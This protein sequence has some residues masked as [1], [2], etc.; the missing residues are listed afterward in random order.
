MIKFENLFKAKIDYMI[1]NI[2]IVLVNTSHPGNIGATARAM[3]CMGFKEL[4]LVAPKY[5]PSVDATARAAGADDILAHAKVCD[6][7]HEAV[8]DCH[9][10][11][12]TSARVRSLSLPLL[13]PKELV[14]EI[15]NAQNNSKIAIVFGRENNGLTNEELQLCNCQVQIP[16]SPD[17]SS[18]N[19]A[20]AVQVIVYELFNADLVHNQSDRQSVTN[21]PVLA[22]ASDIADFYRRLEQ[23]L[24]VMNFL[25]PNNP[26]RL[27]QRIHRMFSRIKLE[28]IELG[29]LQGIL[30]KIVE[31]LR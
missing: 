6:L 5:F 24:V 26:K 2:R 30:T 8:S 31:L 14:G 23:T 1:S 29:I 28:K 4:F 16:T 9:L 12:A 10:V 21:S 22:T 15:S 3:K 18:L 13:T 25:Q 27:M 7:F 19:I 11:V 17:F 20:A